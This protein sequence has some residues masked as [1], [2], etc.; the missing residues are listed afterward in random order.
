MLILYIFL[1]FFYKLLKKIYI[2]IYIYIYSCASANEKWY[3]NIGVAIWQRNLLYTYTKKRQNFPIYKR[4]SPINKQRCCWK[5]EKVLV[6][7]LWMID[8]GLEAIRHHEVGR[9]SLIKVK[10]KG[11]YGYGMLKIKASLLFQWK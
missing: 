4:K 9:F 8:K 3:L 10:I 7:K 6:E 1:C 2:S 5:I 11:G